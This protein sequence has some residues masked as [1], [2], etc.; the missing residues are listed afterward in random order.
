MVAYAMMRVVFIA[1]ASSLK[2]VRIG[3]YSI[4]KD[5]KCL[6]EIMKLLMLRNLWT[7]VFT[8]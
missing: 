3:L 1:M 8:Q 6:C 2:L 4:E 7:Y 5:D